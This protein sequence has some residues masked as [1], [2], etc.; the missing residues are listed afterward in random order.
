[1]ALGPRGFPGLC[2][3]SR[4]KHHAGSSPLSSNVRPHSP[5]LRM[6]KLL[7]VLGS[8]LAIG[9]VWFFAAFALLEQGLGLS[10][11]GLAVAAMLIAC[12][13]AGAYVGW[14]LFVAPKRSS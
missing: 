1:M 3:A 7:Y 12:I 11:S 4:P 8:A 10:L 5:H 14:K 6:L 9:L 13:G 2:S